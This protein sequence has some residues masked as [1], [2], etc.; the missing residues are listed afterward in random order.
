[1]QTHDSGTSVTISSQW[2]LMCAS[3]PAAWTTEAIGRTMAAEMSP[4]APPR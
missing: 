2:R 4:W 1:M 3:T